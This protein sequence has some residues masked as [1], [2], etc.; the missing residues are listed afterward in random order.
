M[1]GS[2]DVTIRC[3]DLSKE[4]CDAIV[5]PTNVSMCPDGGLDSII[6]QSMGQF[7]T[8]QVVAIHK[9]MKINSCP[10]GQSRI[11]IAKFNRESQD[12]RYVISTVGPLYSEEDKDRAAF[13]L[14]SCYYTSLALANLYQLSSIAYPAI[15][16]G[17][18]GFPVAE[19]AN[20]AIES[21]RNYS[22]SVK[23]VRFVLYDTPI[24]D[25]FVREW[26]NYAQKI[27]QEA[28]IAD[29]TIIES[30]S[31]LQT[32][33]SPSARPCVL[34][35]KRQLP[36]DRQLLCVPCSELKRPELFDIFLSNLR[37]AATTSYDNLQQ[38]CRLLKPILKS[39][40]LVY[41]PAQIF[42][43]S[44]H[45]RDSTAEHYLQSHCDKLFRN[46]MP[47]AVLGDGNCFY[48]TFV[49]LGG[50]GTTTD[51]ST[52][53]PI[54]L[55]ARNV[56]EL[57]LNVNAYQSQ[58]SALT[59]ILDGFEEYVRK[60]MVRDTNYAAVWDLLSIPTVLNIH[61]ISVYPKVNGLEDLNYQYL[62]NTLF[63]PLPTD[64]DADNQGKKTE[65]TTI[66]KEVKLLFSHCH[67]PML[68]FSKNKKD[69]VP[70]HF[71]PLL[72]FT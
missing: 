34:C 38:E 67:R 55:R 35:K 14:K 24:Y 15:A 26:T 5:N 6:H 3:G 41:N 2:L 69:W 22:Y 59:A 23:D 62:N 37:S 20:V 16:C 70:N 17:A 12:A 18:N 30:P 28:N 52:L 44:I 57:V 50:V 65:T 1:N 32:P 60:E 4:P 29:Q 58:Y 63:I 61:V 48:N 25:I 68:G 8:D 7:F 33:S 47:M 45:Q 64:T 54:E 46:T 27:N 9:D 51:A 71:V 56:V 10:H 66:V 31:K 43:Q 49:K 36:I 21:I 40:P 39:Y 72:G 42:D 13:L 53:T 19:A 11:F